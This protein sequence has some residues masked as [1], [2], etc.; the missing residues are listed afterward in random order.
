MPKLLLAVVHQWLLLLDFCEHAPF[1]KTWTKYLYS[2]SVI[3]SHD[4]ALVNTGP[5]E[6]FLTSF[7]HVFHATFAGVLTVAYI[8]SKTCKLAK[9]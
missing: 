2:L 3:L 8:K 9:W 1:F 5:Q 4:G 6:I 7:C